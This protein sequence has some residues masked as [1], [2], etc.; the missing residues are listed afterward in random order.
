MIDS[1]EEMD[2]TVSGSILSW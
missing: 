1:L 2:P